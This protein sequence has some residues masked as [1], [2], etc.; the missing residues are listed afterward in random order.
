MTPT[1][2]TLSLLLILF[3]AM[4]VAGFYITFIHLID[5]L[6]GFFFALEVWDVTQDQSL[7][8]LI[9]ALSLMV[10]LFGIFRKAPEFPV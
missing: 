7:A 8:V 10:F 3:L 5:G 9:F 6:L 4:M 1:D 2:W